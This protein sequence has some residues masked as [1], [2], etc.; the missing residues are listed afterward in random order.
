M[1]EVSFIYQI[2]KH[3]KRVR[4]HN[5]RRVRGRVVNRTG[6][7][8]KKMKWPWKGNCQEMA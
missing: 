2:L 6:D 8:T 1:Y 4:E 7:K 3:L 5:G